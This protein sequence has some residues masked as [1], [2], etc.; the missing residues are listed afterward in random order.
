MYQNI[1]PA[2]FFGHCWGKHI[3]GC[4][5]LDAFRQRHDFVRSLQRHTQL[6]YLHAIIADKLDPN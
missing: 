6:S 2:E 5:N 3:F 1:Y 4:E